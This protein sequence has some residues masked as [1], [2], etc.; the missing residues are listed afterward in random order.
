VVGNLGVDDVAAR[1]GTDDEK[2]DAVP[3]AVGS[4]RVVVVK[5]NV[6][7]NLFLNGHG[8]DTLVLVER[9]SGS[10]GVVVKL[11]SL[12]V[13]ENECGL[14]VDVRIGLETLKNL[15]GPVLTGTRVVG[16]VLGLDGRGDYP[17][18]LRES[19]GLYVVR[20]LCDC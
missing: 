12:V 1:P 11:S 5:K 3:E 4:G 15:S 7:V 9:R 18:D 20:E 13:V 19:V 10:E 17:G 2:G 6:T 8:G 14:G 16:G